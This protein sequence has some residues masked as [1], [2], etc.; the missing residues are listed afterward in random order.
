MLSNLSWKI[1]FLDFASRKF[2]ILYVHF[3]NLEIYSEDFL[4]ILDASVV[5]LILGCLYCKV[6]LKLVPSCFQSGGKL[7]LQVRA[8]GFIAVNPKCY[9]ESDWCALRFPSI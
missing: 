4:K 9:L 3:L 1:R 8:A 5:V 7:C 6:C 2:R